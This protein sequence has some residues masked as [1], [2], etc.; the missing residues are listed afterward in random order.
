MILDFF[1]RGIVR[2]SMSKN[3]ELRTIAQNKKIAETIALEV[4]GFRSLRF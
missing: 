1:F 4:A 2:I 3:E